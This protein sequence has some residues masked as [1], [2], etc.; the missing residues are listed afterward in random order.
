MQENSGQKWK[1][2]LSS[3]VLNQIQ[4]S[5]KDKDK[6]ETLVLL[7]QANQGSWLNNLCR[8]AHHVTFFHARKSSI[9][10]IAS[11]TNLVAGV[12]DCLLAWSSQPPTSAG[13]CG[14]MTAVRAST[15]RVAQHFLK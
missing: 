5:D 8:K 2:S 11:L 14:S 10:L 13:C 12:I 4:A 15:F 9:W 3:S 6:I 7:P 1:S